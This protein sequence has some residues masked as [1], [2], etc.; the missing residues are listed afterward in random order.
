MQDLIHNLTYPE[1]LIS[2]HAYN[3]NTYVRFGV[4]QSCNRKI[5]D[6][7]GS[8][9]EVGRNRKKHIQTSRRTKQKRWL[10][11]VEDDFLKL[12]ERTGRETFVE[13]EES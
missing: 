13:V 8:R 9:C 11:C 2:L 7:S 10:R 12:G 6:T 5:T 4:T 1:I 3:L